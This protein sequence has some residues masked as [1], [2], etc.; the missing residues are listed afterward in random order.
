MSSHSARHCQCIYYRVG[1]VD[2]NRVCILI[3]IYQLYFASHGAAVTS[4]RER[5][6]LQTNNTVN[7]EQVIST[8]NYSS[9]CMLI[10]VQPNEAL[11]SFS[12]YASVDFVRAK[13][14]VSESCKIIL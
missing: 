7:T 6:K 3:Y 12:F 1:K 4:K 9:I 2:P 13:I 14:V 11:L 5:K 10:G 8:N